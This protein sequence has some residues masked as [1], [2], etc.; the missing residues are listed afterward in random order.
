MPHFQLLFTPPDFSRYYQSGLLDD[1]DQLRISRHPQLNE[2]PCWRN[3][4]ALKQWVEPRF[5]DH[6]FCLSHKNDHALIALGNTQKPG[7]DLEALR[8]RDTAALIEQIGNATEKSHL[9]ACDYDLLSFYRLWT[10]KEALI[11]AED[12][13]FPTDMPHVGICHFQPWTL[14]TTQLHDPYWLSA[15]LSEQ[16]VIAGVWPRETRNITQNN[17]LT[18]HSPQPLALSEI[19][20]N[21]PALTID[22]QALPEV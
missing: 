7:V 5:A 8:E 10:L 3:S 11:K 12:L 18:L 4:R 2:R 16:W 17:H 1:K 9:A 14:Q 22:W 19:I 15:R 21:I 6:G 13:R 20:S